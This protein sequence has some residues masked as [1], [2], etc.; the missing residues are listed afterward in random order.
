[1]FDR[2]FDH[3]GQRLSLDRL[4]SFLRVAESGGIARA[5]PGNQSL[6]S[7]LSRQLSELESFFGRPLSERSGRGRVLTPAGA[8]LAR[9]LRETFQQLE[10]L[11]T[12]G[13]EDPI[14]FELGAGDSLLHWWIVPRIGRVLAALPGV[15]LGLTSL[16]VKG[17]VDRL[18]EAR[19]DVGVVRATELPRSRE[20]DTRLLGLVEYAVYV[21]KDVMARARARSVE[22]VLASVPL[23]LQQSEPRLN[24][25]LRSF[26]D[27]ELPVALACETFPQACRA[28]RGGA[29]ASL[30]PVLARD[31]LPPRDFAELRPPEVKKLTARM[32]LAWHPRLLRQRPRA[33]LLIDSLAR[34]LRL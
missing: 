29:Y 28:V 10:D 33:K 19:L 17:I 11:A 4:R 3:P 23:A 22:E 26:V 15:S 30:L 24:D 18:E 12:E 21:R 2:L 8:R 34:D 5:A 20:V 27:G 31:E 25:C 1:M 32:A 9:L 7:Q 13:G 6:Q 14:R 16:S